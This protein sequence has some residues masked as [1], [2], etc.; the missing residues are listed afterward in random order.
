MARQIHGVYRNGKVELLEKP[1]EA[2]QE[3]PVIVTFLDERS[4]D[5]PRCGIDQERAAELRNQLMAF[6]GEWDSPEMQ[7]YDDY[8]AAKS[9]L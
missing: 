2:I 8:D 6:A 4:I 7:P 3:A 1:D 5:L 9:R